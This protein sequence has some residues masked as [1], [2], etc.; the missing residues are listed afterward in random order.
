MACKVK[1]IYYLALQ[2][3][4]IEPCS[5]GVLVRM[6][7]VKL[8]ETCHE[9]RCPAQGGCSKP[10]FNFHELHAPLLSPLL[11]LSSSRKRKSRGSNYNVNSLIRNILNDVFIM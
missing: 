6:W 5:A 4:V 1:N 10:A 9:F 8:V 11:L 2:R 7:D 3:K